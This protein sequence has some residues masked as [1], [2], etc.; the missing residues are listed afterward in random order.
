MSERLFPEYF[1]KYLLALLE[2]E[3]KQMF[4]WEMLKRVADRSIYDLCPGCLWSRYGNCNWW[5]RTTY[6]C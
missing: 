2:R 5:G 3:K 4:S 6:A 1:D